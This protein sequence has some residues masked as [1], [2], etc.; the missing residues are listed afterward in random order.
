MKFTGGVRGFLELKGWV[1]RKSSSGYDEEIKVMD[2]SQLWNKRR[3]E[4]DLEVKIR[5]QKNATWK[6]S[7]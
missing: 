7:F 4:K 2:C 3:G 1:R 5:L 6:F